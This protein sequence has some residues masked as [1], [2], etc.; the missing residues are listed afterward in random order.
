[1]RII[2]T[3]YHIVPSGD[4]CVV[5]LEY[6]LTD[7]LLEGYIFTSFITYRI[8]YTSSHAYQQ[9]TVTD[10]TSAKSTARIFCATNINF[11]IRI[12]AII[13]KANCYD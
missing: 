10:I 3:S 7:K 5:E 6:D 8:D 4:N 1:M 12:V 9:V 13:V 11:V 2:D